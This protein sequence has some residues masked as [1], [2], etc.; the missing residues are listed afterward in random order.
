MNITEKA[1]VRKDK[2]AFRESSV[3]QARELDIEKKKVVELEAQ[4]AQGNTGKIRHLIGVY[5]EKIRQLKQ[6]LGE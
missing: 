2:A 6:K 1:E 3:E 4:I 5:E